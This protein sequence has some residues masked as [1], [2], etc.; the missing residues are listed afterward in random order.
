MPL[1]AERRRRRRAE[2]RIKTLTCQRCGE[3]FQAAR[4]DKKYCSDA[5]RKPHFRTAKAIERGLRKLARL[6][7]VDIYLKDRA[8][9]RLNPLHELWKGAPAVSEGQGAVVAYWRRLRTTGHPLLRGVDH[10]AL[11]NFGGTALGEIHHHNIPSALDDATEA[12]ALWWQNAVDV[13]K[14][15]VGDWQGVHMRAR[16]DKGEQAPTKLAGE[17]ESGWKGEVLKK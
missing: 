13:G 3:V 16:V 6:L 10:H 8:R 11:N 4:R 1:S 7:R 15:S 12:P 2:Q 5:C 9:K 14:A 17:D